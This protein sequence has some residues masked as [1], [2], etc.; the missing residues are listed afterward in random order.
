MINLEKKKKKKFL[1]ECSSTKN[2]HKTNRKRLSRKSAK[3]RWRNVLRA[4]LVG[5]RTLIIS[6]VLFFPRLIP[7]ALA[8]HSRN[9]REKWFST[10][11]GF[12]RV[13]YTAFSSQRTSFS[14]FSTLPSLVVF[15]FFP[16]L[17]LK[18][19]LNEACFP[20][21]EASFPCIFGDGSGFHPILF[22]L[23]FFLFAN[24]PYLIFEVLTIVIYVLQ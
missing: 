4:G 12:L 3:S 19:V 17:N 18:L 2:P 8:K 23:F 1:N 14:Y 21:S 11:Y 6:L 15:F 16:V 13:D 22:H 10:F 7:P 24:K 9:A 20:P 5:I